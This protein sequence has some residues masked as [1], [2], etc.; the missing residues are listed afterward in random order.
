[1]MLLP[2]RFRLWLFPPAAPPAARVTDTPIHPEGLTPITATVE[3]PPER[4]A[5]L[6][7][8]Q[9]RQ[10]VIINSLTGFLARRQTEQLRARRQEGRQV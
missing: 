10:H 7:A 3:I 6:E 5:L 4:R 2:V 9:E 1:M 8:V